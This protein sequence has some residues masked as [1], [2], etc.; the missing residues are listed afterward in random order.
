MLESSV[1]G[2]V[3]H[4][5][6]RGMH[7]GCLADEVGDEVVPVAVEADSPALA[8]GLV[9]RHNTAIDLALY[10]ATPSA[11]AQAG[12]NHSVAAVRQQPGGR[13]PFEL[14]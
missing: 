8:E 11:C 13:C 4:R 3:E 5:F 10:S 14:S 1:D 7:G 9:D 12:A 2:S 6:P